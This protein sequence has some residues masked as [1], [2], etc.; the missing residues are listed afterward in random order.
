MGNSFG[1]FDVAGVE[2]SLQ[3]V[4]RVLRPGA[5]FVLESATVAE[6][7]LPGLAAETSHRFGG[8][9]IVGYHR[10]EPEYDRCVSVLHIDDGTTRSVRT[11]QQLVLPADRICHFLERAGLTVEHRLGGTDWR[12]YAAGDGSLIVV[13]RRR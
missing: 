9:E 3:E 5:R 12:H 6:S 2:S 4:A 13:A 8:V 10:Y 1:Y 7:L 11:M